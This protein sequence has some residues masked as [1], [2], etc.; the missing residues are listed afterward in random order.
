VPIGTTDTA[1][2][3]NVFVLPPPSTDSGRWDL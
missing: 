3:R 1:R 2:Q